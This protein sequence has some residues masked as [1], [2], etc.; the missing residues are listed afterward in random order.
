MCM[1][2]LC[3]GMWGVYARVP[4]LYDLVYIYPSLCVCE[5]HNLC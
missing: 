2:G 5:G 4:A 3:M 1:D